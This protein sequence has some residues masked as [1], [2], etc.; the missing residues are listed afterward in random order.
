[1]LRRHE[2]SNWCK[3]TRRRKVNWLGETENEG[4]LFAEGGV[5]SSKK[6]ETSIRSE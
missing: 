4:Q 2:E 6:A 3:N 5:R 1:V